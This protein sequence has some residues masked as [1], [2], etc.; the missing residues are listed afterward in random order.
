MVLEAIKQHLEETHGVP[1]RLETRCSQ[2]DYLRIGSG[3]VLLLTITNKGPLLVDDNSAAYLY[4]DLADPN[5]LDRLD[6]LV[7]LARDAPGR[8]HLTPEGLRDPATC[9]LV[10]RA[11]RKPLW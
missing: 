3:R 9:S 2:P 1:V 7:V 6:G 11:A 8:H 10:D 4:L 5:F